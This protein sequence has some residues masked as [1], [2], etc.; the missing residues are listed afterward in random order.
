MIS[1]A[2]L[3]TLRRKQRMLLVKAFGSLL[4]M[5]EIIVGP[6]MLLVRCTSSAALREKELADVAAEK[7]RYQK[8]G[9]RCLSGWDGSHS[10][11]VD[12]FKKSLRD[13]GSF[14]HD[15][16]IMSPRDAMGKH[17]L[18]MKYRAENGFGGMNVGYVKATV[19]NASCSFKILESS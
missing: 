19:D 12:L 11:L 6:I 14:A 1:E 18:I 10:G 7:A 17:N 3:K 5:I 15:Q 2:G 8:S 4:F 9:E 16:T 13:P